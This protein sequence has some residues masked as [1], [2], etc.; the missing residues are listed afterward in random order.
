MVGT[1]TRDG[2]EGNMD[3]SVSRLIIGVVVQQEKTNAL[4]RTCMIVAEL[5]RA[6]IA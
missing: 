2:M 3:V 5:R 6:I 4:E 1:H